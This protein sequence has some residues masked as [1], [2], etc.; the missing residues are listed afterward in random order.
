M[1]A[2][3][4]AHYLE[5]EWQE[6]GRAR[7]IR[8]APEPI[9][10]S[11]LDGGALLAE[12]QVFHNLCPWVGLRLEGELTAFQPAFEGA[13][14]VPTP[15][16]RLEDGR[17]GH[18]WVQN[19]GWDPVG[20]RHLSELH[21]T[22]GQFSIVLG[23]HRL[24]LNNVIDGL[25][26]VEVE[27][28]LR[29][30]QHDLVWL[31]MGFG[32][33]TGTADSGFKINRELIE[34][35]EAFTAAAHQVLAR[36]ACAMREVQV[37]SF[38]ARLR[39]NSATF[40]QYL[41]TPAAQRLPG[42]GAE[43]TSDIS[44]NR[45]LRHLVQVCEKL[46]ASLAEAVVQQAERF[47]DR[48]R[49]EAERSTA[50]K[51][52]T[53]REV[54]PDIFDR[55]LAELEKK[56][57]RVANYGDALLAPYDRLRALEFRAGAP[58][59]RSSN[60]IFFKNKDGSTA[61]GESNG[62]KYEFSVLQLPE[63][64]VEAIQS[65]Q[66]F[67]DYYQLRGTG[68]AYPRQTAKGKPYREIQFTGVY[69]A[70]PFTR[71]LER[72]LDKRARLEKNGWL[73]P[74]TTKE[75]DESQ[76]EARTAHLR[77]QTYRQYGQQAEQASSVL[78]RCQKELKAQNLSWQKLGVAAATTLPMG[79]RFSQSPTYAAC[80]VAFSRLTELAQQGGIELDTLD[81]LDRIG[82]LHAS[83][84]YERWCLV[85]LLS[86]LL[87]DYRFQPEAGWQERLVRAIA[88]K[89]ESLE[90]K[91]HRADVG[92]SACLEIQPVL[93]NGRRPDFRL[94]FSYDN[95]TPAPDQG[96]AGPRWKEAPEESLD[97]KR[98]TGGLVLDAKFRT[99]WRRGELGRTLTSLLKEKG[100]DQQGDRVFILHPAP[101]AI[102]NP[103]SPLSWGKDCD[104]GQEAG[105]SHKNGVVYL[106]AGAGAANPEL[107]LRRLIILQL[108]ATFPAPIAV[109]LKGAITWESRS[110]CIRCGKAHQP[111]DVRQQLTRRGGT[112]WIL[113]CSECQMQTTRT[114]C[115]GCGSSLIFKNGLNLTYHRTVAD[116]VTNVVC[117][118]CGKYFDND[119]HG[120][121]NAPDLQDS[122]V[123][124]HW[125]V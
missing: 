71:A 97:S 73:A 119:V 17:G 26:R 46:C 33:A 2:T 30:F 87:E 122:V 27:Q 123:P 22:M 81:A 4:H 62:N 49:L 112:F 45:Y 96:N 3:L 56:L 105:K 57:A 12:T 1:I 14:G 116:Q 52:L 90:L 85:K 5:I 72:K 98:T 115:Y 15:M 28:Y 39:P 50:Y 47:A 7:T 44:D 38:P 80:K 59:G 55:Q 21:R 60:T 6:F 10:I 82:V 16:L 8:V 18:W 125:S 9:E 92:L 78:K 36:P 100:Y 43:E 31:V 74:L 110:F 103:T 113:S 106:A 121:E 41:R 61:A 75:R 54:D 124:E 67:C 53:Q 79:V 32:G 117:P 68:E 84:L 86:V 109:E 77:E 93:P 94:C 120:R 64:L 102:L 76:Q 58:Y 107:N 34:A 20:K 23:P 42:R 70:K 40:R 111:K 11:E 29:D 69:S 101:K 24:L 99:S 95:V 114:H 89:P 63:A 13:D 88:G 65:T 83:A 51:N 48:A 35:L 118:Q 25:G 19:D 108:Q 91:L 104:Y 37:E 66:S